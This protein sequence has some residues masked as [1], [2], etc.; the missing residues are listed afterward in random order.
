MRACGQVLLL[1]RYGSSAAAVA[2]ELAKKGYS[3]VFVI[4]GA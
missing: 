2:K 3:N 1:D 4:T